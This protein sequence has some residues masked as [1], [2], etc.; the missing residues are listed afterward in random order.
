MKLTDRR[1]QFLQQ[2]IDMYQR[3]QLPVH[4]ESLAKMIGVSKWTAYD[5]LRELEKLGLLSRNYSLSRGEAGRSQIVFLP[6]PKAYE[7]FQQERTTKTGSHEWLKVRSN[8]LELIDL[9]EQHSPKKTV[10]EL[11]NQ[12]VSAQTKISFCAYVIGLLIVHLRGLDKSASVLIR[13]L[14]DGVEN[15]ETRLSVFVALVLGTVIEKQQAAIGA[16]AATLIGRFW[17]EIAFLPSSDKNLL[18]QL[19]DEILI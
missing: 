6:T 9:A 1:K 19:L 13:H 10:S 17:E 5:M 8:I 3:S 4:Y 7:L 12:L 11:V 18:L 15:A 14:I 2:L 16:E